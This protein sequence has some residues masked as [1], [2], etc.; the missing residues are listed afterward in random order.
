MLQATTLSVGDG[1]HASRGNRHGPRP[2]LNPLTRHRVAGQ[3][4]MPQS[5]IGAP[6]KSS[7]SCTDNHSCRVC[8]TRGHP[9]DEQATARVHPCD[10]PTRRWTGCTATPTN[11]W[12]RA[13]SDIGFL[14]V[15]AIDAG[16]PRRDPTIDGCRGDAREVTRGIEHAAS[17]EPSCIGAVMPIAHGVSRR[18]PVLSGPPTTATIPVL[19]VS[20][21]LPEHA[22]RK[23]NLPNP[24]FGWSDGR[25][26]D[27]RFV[28]GRR[29]PWRRG[30]PGRL[31][32]RTG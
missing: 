16:W 21:L 3:R 5:S 24:W 30:L 18:R 12:S 10:V 23:N 14:A 9:N 11:I 28:L 26:G 31:G 19:A 1:G 8:R 32:V 4:G 2:Q 15:R 27:A 6:A 25:S 20:A 17:G 29:F 22:E 13:S 7:R